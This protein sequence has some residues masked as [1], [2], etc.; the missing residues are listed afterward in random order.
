MSRSTDKSKSTV[1]TVDSLPLRN[2]GL[3]SILE[4]LSS[5]RKFRVVSL[6]PDDAEKWIDNDGKCSMITYNVG[7]ASVADHKHSKRIKTLR[8]RAAEVPLVI[9]SDSN[10]RKEVLSALNVGAQ[11]F[12]YAGTDVRL[13]QKALSFILEGGSYFPVQ[14]RLGRPPRRSPVIIND[15]RAEAAPSA[16]AARADED[17]V[18]APSVNIDLSGRQK[19]VLEC[20]VRGDS[21]KGIA[22]QLGI[23]EATVKVHVQRIM[24]KLGVV[25]RTQVVIAC[26]GRPDENSVRGKMELSRSDG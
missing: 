16:D 5:T 24:R 11:G 15:S 25:N 13:A 26:R 20:L 18:V 7:C 21:N 9:F 6:M 1:L 3:V 23:R 4:R 22:R 10:S 8:A 2:L 17:P 19:A 12:L 14:A